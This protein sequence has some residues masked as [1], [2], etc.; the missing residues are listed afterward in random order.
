MN[1]QS[2]IFEQ[3]QGV[4]PVIPMR[5]ARLSAE[6]KAVYAY[7]CAFADLEGKVYVYSWVLCKELGIPTQRFYRLRNK[8]EA[9]GYISKALPPRK[10]SRFSG[11]V[12]TLNPDPEGQASR[13]GRVCS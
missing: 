9:L 13:V 10:T 4:L 6:A 1:S 7:L 11:Y 12:Y 2:P 5:D 8:L 3:G